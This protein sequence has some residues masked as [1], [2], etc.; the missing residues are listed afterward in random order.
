MLSAAVRRLSEDELLSFFASLN[1]EGAVQAR[2][3]SPH[4]VRIYCAGYADCRYRGIA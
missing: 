2:D 3:P 1:A 4:A